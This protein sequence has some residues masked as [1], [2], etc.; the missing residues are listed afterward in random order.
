[1]PNRDFKPTSRVGTERR[2]SMKYFSI[3]ELTHSTKAHELHIDNTPFSYSIIDNLVNLIDNLL[4]PLREAWNAPLI[5]TS[6]YR[7]DALNR[8][9][10]GSKTS[11]HRYGLAADV[12][13]KNMADFDEFAAFVKDFLK[14][15]EYDQLILEQKGSSRWLHIGYKSAEGKQRM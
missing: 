10:G 11:A 7:S 15:K 3:S 5:I 8:A 4:D 14:D 13:P 1:M 2:H 9:V 12:V 6:G